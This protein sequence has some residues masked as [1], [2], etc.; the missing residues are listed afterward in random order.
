MTD[1]QTDRPTDHATQSV[2]T[3]RIYVRSTAIRPNSNKLITVVI[4]YLVLLSY[5][6][7]NTAV[8]YDVIHMKIPLRLTACNLKTPEPVLQFWHSSMPFCKLPLA[9]QCSYIIRILEYFRDRPEYSNPTFR[10]NPS[11][12]RRRCSKYQ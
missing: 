3:G 12:N 7:Q 2:T 11:P 6:N 9:A 8:M 1:R 10:M 5:Y 4:A